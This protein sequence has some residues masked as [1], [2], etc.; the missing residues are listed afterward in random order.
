MEIISGDTTVL[1]PDGDL[2]YAAGEPDPDSTSAL[3]RTLISEGSDAEREPLARVAGLRAK[4][5]GSTDTGH[6]SITDPAYPSKTC[7]R[8]TS[9]RPTNRTSRPPRSGWSPAKYW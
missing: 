3:L 8:K 1:E 2:A 7:S 4:I 6:A 9:A 5:T